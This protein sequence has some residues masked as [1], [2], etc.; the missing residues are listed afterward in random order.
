M[1]VP[2][3]IRLNY[4]IV[5]LFVT[6]MALCLAPASYN[7]QARTIT[8]RSTLVLT[9]IRQLHFAGDVGMLGLPESMR[10]ELQP[11]QAYVEWIGVDPSAT[12]RG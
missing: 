5:E 7:Y 3:I 2:Q 4:S 11:K 10:H 1:L 8:L 6:K 9:A 12:G